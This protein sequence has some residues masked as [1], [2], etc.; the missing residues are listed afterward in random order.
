MAP[1]EMPGFTYR[2]MI[3]FSRTIS[4]RSS[5]LPGFSGWSEWLAGIFLHAFNE[6]KT[7]ASPSGGEVNVKYVAF[8]PLLCI[9]AGQFFE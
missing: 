7:A 5:S 2:D 4:R 3:L 9:K 1:I 8:P 6:K